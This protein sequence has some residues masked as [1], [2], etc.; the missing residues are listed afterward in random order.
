MI[1]LHTVHSCFDFERVCSAQQKNHYQISGGTNHRDFLQRCNDYE[2]C[3]VNVPKADDADE[4]GAEAAAAV[5]LQYGVVL[6]D[7]VGTV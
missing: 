5:N 7:L 6:I 1:F 2:I 4:E 3:E